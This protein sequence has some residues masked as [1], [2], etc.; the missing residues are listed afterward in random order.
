MT[1]GEGI[2]IPV[3]LCFVS[4]LF[5]GSN[6]HGK[7]WAVRMSCR[8]EEKKKLKGKMYFGYESRTVREAHSSLG[9]LSP[10]AR[11]NCHT[12][13]DPRKARSFLCPLGQKSDLPFRQ[14][15]GAGAGNRTKEALGFGFGGRWF[16]PGSTVQRLGVHL[17]LL[18]TAEEPKH[19]V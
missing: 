14:R 7:P 4:G 12:Q 19:Q 3:L 17:W 10:G 11:G 16:A 13:Q 1:W 6:W 15:H 18:W 5:S 9:S 8:L 2:C